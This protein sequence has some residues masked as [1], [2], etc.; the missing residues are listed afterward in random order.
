MALIQKKFK[1]M[2]IDAASGITTLPSQDASI[3]FILHSPRRQ[4]RRARGTQRVPSEILR[5]CLKICL[6]LVVATN[7]ISHHKDRDSMSPP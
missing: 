3:C 4:K 7:S 5:L 6:G 2:H 1:S